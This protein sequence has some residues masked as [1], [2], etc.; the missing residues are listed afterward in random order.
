MH[1][2]FGHDQLEMR[3]A[4]R[5][6]LDRACT[7]E[8]LRSAWEGPVEGL[9]AVLAELGILGINAPESSGGLGL[10][11]VDWVLI[12]EESGR[13]ALP[14][15]LVEVV[16]A[17]PFLDELGEQALLSGLV[18]GEK[19]VSIAFED[20]Y[21]LD[22]D[23]A[24]RVFRARGDSVYAVHDPILHAQ[25]SMDGARALFSVEGREEKL[26]GDSSALIQRGVLACSAQLLGLGRQVVEMAVAYSKERRQF[27]VPIGSFQAVQHQLVDA[28]LKLR[29]A[30]PLVY[31]AAWS[32]QEEDPDRALHVSMA[33]IYA[34]EAAL[35]ACK[36]SLQVHGAIGYTFEMDLHL[37]MKRIWA[38]AA[39]W[40][41]A[42]Y[43]RN[44][45]AA[46]VFGGIDA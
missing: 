19:R 28:L 37:W 20:G 24:E 12:L 46:A 8:T 39:D 26:E 30:A 9:R 45:A 16:A 29:F 1:F 35:F 17:A 33:K 5:S 43:H 42:A 14:E 23:R 11:A 18:S 4:V 21:A 22:A 3:D 25:E 13:V 10:K 2:A 31:R 32:L 41:D 34:S 6:A 7:P 44:K 38:L 36:K 27:G 15:S 40:G